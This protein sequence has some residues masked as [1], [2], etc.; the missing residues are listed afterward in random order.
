M[1]PDQAAPMGAVRSRFIFFL[2]E[3]ILSKVQQTH[4]AENIFKTKYSGGTKVNGI[5]EN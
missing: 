2:R 3:K 1:D 5:N 4:K